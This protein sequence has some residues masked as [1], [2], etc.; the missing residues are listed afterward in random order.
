[1]ANFNTSEPRRYGIFVQFYEKVHLLHANTE[2]ECVRLPFLVYFWTRFFFFSCRRQFLTLLHFLFF[3]NFFFLFFLSFFFFFKTLISYTWGLSTE[4]NVILLCLDLFF[5]PF[6]CKECRSKHPFSNDSNRNVSSTRNSRKS[7][8]FCIKK[9]KNE[10]DFEHCAW[11]VRKH[12]MHDFLLRKQFFP[13]F[14]I[15]SAIPPWIIH[16]FWSL[17]FFLFFP[18]FFSAR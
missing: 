2:S 10:F 16:I 18:S 8:S 17:F 11:V 1:M 9:K 14:S 7:T 12:Y 5:F 4:H 3:F 15:D 6:E 13:P